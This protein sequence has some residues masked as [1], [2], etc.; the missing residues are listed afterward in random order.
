MKA[1]D[2]LCRQVFVTSQAP[3]CCAA[4]AS[5]ATLT[6]T[7]AQKVI[8]GLCGQGQKLEPI[9]VISA[10]QAP[11]LRYDPIRKIFFQQDNRQSL[12]GTAEASAAQPS[13]PSLIP[14]DCAHH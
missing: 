8:D 5:T 2:Q 14:S 9:Q 1:A 6:Q 7:E 12:H 13:S 4:C 3:P 10:F 11:K